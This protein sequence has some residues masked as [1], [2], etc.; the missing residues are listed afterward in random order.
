MCGIVGYYGQNS[1]EVVK[2]MNNIQ[3]H[4]GPDEDGLYFSEKYNF[5]M[6]MRRLAIVDLSNG[7]QPM[8]SKDGRYILIFNGEIFNADVLR[9]ELEDLGVIFRTSNSDTEVLLELLIHKGE[10]SIIELNGMFSFCFHD[11]KKGTLLIARDRFG[12]KP[13]YYTE[14][15]E[16]FAFASELKSIL[17]IKGFT[18]ELDY[19]SVYHYLSLNFI[20]GRNSVYKN[21]KRLEPGALIKLEIPS[22]KILSKKWHEFKFGGS[23]LKNKKEIV[24]KTKDL[25]N[26]ATKRWCASDVNV[27]SLLSGGLDSS[28]ISYYAKK[29]GI[30]IKTFTVGFS[31]MHEE[32]YDES[33][34]AKKIAGFIGTHH[35]HISLSQNDL[36]KD[37]SKIAWH[38]DEP[39]GGGIPSWSVFKA[40]GNDYKV[41]LTG[42]GGDELFGNYNKWVRLDGRVFSFF[43]Q[44]KSEVSKDEFI[45]KYLKLHYY[46]TDKLKNNILL[47]ENFKK[48][49]FE[50]TA[51][52]MWNYFNQN[53]LSSRDSVVYTDINTQLPEEFLL[54]TDR[55][56]M[57]HSVEARTPFLDN[58]L[59]NF[60]F[61]LSSNLR[62]S[63]LNYKWILKEIASDILPKEISNL[64]KKG[65]VLPR[66]EWLQGDLKKSFNDLT[67]KS[68][69]NEQGIFNPNFLDNIHLEKKFNNKD[70]IEILWPIY[71]YQLWSKEIHE[72]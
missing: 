29:N 13:L 33:Q 22:M 55:L 41:A 63:R 32:R 12:I 42:T 66:K 71:M 59:S 40:I 64:P 36:L 6:A 19:N 49:A 16:Y 38:L 25:L 61:S 56:S 14:G 11:T 48:E 57:A 43:R 15:L 69:L 20:P 60:I 44:R 58:E 24:E 67:C 37:I 18:K 50:D 53:N 8:V 31:G 2:L 35:N 54:M 65:F 45:N 4:R 9:S 72:A 68:R 46:A 3:I 5:S 70:S 21:I 23:N 10:N 1:Q 26:A 47:S 17:N 7:Q 51:D 39:Y 34:A 28:L 62:L 27:S 52:I 30:D